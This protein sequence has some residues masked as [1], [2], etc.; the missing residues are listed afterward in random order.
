MF[1]DVDEA[2]AMSWVCKKGSAFGHRFQDA[3][4]SL[5]AQVNVKSTVLGD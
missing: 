4:R 5:D 3:R 1:G 2:N